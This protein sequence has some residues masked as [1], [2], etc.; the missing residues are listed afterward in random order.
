MTVVVMQ[1]ANLPGNTALTNVYLK[2]TPASSTL[3]LD[4]ALS[5]DIINNTVRSTECFIK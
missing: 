2:V 3:V 4:I 1:E 5:G